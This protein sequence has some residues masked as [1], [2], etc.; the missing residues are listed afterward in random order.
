MTSLTSDKD[1]SI[2]TVK[3]HKIKNKSNMF[4]SVNEKKKNVKIS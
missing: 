1:N 4:V 3:S 2:Q